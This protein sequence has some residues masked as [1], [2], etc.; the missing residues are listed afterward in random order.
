MRFATSWIQK[1]QSAK[2]SRTAVSYLFV[3]LPGTLYLYLTIFSVKPRRD[4]ETSGNPKHYFISCADGSLAIDQSRVDALCDLMPIL[5]NLLFGHPQMEPKTLEKVNGTPV[6]EIPPA[7]QVDKSC[8]LLLLKCSMGVKP[9]P[10]R[11]SFDSKVLEETMDKLGGCKSLEKKLQ[12]QNATPLPKYYPKTP[13]DD[14]EER[15][16]WKVVLKEVFESATN[17]RLSGLEEKGYSLTTTYN[18]GGT[19]YFVFRKE[20]M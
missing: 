19:T 20:K 16:L 8:F 3:E 11:Q 18:E 9:L 14:L 5:R 6:L 10:P 1:N 7:L 2:A 17:D 12:K 13:Q 4:M 15:F